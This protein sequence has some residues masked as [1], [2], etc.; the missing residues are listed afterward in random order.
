MLYESSSTKKYN[1]FTSLMA[2]AKTT[3]SQI[4]AQA[5]IGVG[6]AA[7]FYKSFIQRESKPTTENIVS[8]K[9]QFT[10]DVVTLLDKE[11]S[12]NTTGEIWGLRQTNTGES[13]HDE[14]RS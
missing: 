10:S 9:K 12:K 5:G 8:D 1:K 4:L 6:C 3:I 14:R 2:Y 13:R 11:T 7:L